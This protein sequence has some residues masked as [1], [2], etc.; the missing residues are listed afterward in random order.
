MARDV[1]HLF[2]CLLATLC[3]LWRSVYSGPLPIFKWVVC[4]PGVELHEFFIYF[5][6]QTFVRGITGTIYSHMVCSLYTVLMSSLAM[7]KFFILMRSNLFILSFMSLDL[8]DILVKMLLCGI[9]EVFPPMFSS[10]TFMVS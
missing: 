10:R 4:L 9:P 8:G 1:E 3:L 6:D 5:G 2:M 7:Q